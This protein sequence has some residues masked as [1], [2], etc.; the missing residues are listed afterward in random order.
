MSIPNCLLSHLTAITHIQFKLCHWH[1]GTFLFR[2]HWYRGTGTPAVA[3]ATFCVGGLNAANGG[4]AVFAFWRLLGTI[5]F[6]N[7]ARFLNW[8]DSTT[9]EIDETRIIQL[10]LLH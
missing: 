4:V 6:S 7:R 2:Y 5:L 9:V 8:L 1:R 10:C 3:I